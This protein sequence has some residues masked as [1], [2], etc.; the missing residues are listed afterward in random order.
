[1]C[2]Y[3][4]SNSLIQWKNDEIGIV[5]TYENG[6]IKIKDENGKEMEIEL[7]FCPYCGRPVKK[8]VR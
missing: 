7:D 1:M 3:C 6:T 8:K 2:T 4:N 5:V